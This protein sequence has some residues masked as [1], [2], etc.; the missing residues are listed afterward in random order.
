MG[1][2]DHEAVIAIF[3]GAYNTNVAASYVAS[4]DD[5]S[6]YVRPHSA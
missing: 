3:E 6:F 2:Y 1:L 5:Y 4:S